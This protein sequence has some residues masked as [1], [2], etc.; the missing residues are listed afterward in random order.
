MEKNEEGK[1]ELISLE[2]LE[3]INQEAIKFQVDLILIGGYAVR[4]YTNPRSWRYTKDM[5][6][7]TRTKDLGALRVVFA[8]LGYDF[9]KTEFG[10]KGSKKLDKISI[11]LHI[12]VDR[13]LDWSTGLVYKLPDDIF[14]KASDINIKASFEANKGLEV[15]AKVAPVEDIVVMKL[16]TERIKDRFDAVAVILDSFEKMDLSRFIEICNQNNLYQHI[17]N[18][19]YSVLADIKKDLIKKL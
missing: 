8:V 17:R 10:V 2:D 7:I 5:D 15:S 14:T 6:F 16:I 13:V 11:E 1:T 18:R 12:S 3:R 9:N 19:L 4:A